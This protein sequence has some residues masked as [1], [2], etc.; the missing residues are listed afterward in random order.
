[1]KDIYSQPIATAY[2]LCKDRSCKSTSLKLTTYYFLI[3]L[4]L[5]RPENRLK[6]SIWPAAGSQGKYCNV[7]PKEELE[8]IL[9]YH[10]ATDISMIYLTDVTR[11]LNLLKMN[12]E[13]FSTT[14][15][16]IHLFSLFTKCYKHEFAIYP[17]TKYSKYFMC[18]IALL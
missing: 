4:Y 2:I 9:E 1:M 5:N 13:Y 11:S 8:R 10:I 6:R 7:E 14:R 3:F 17:S 12:V 16:L 18:Y 15:C